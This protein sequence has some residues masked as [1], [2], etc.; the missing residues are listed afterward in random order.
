MLGFFHDSMSSPLLLQEANSPPPTTSLSSA[1]TSARAKADAVV[2]GNV[3]SAPPGRGGAVTGA[4]AAVVVGLV[5]VMLVAVVS[6]Y[7]A[8]KRRNDVN[9]DNAEMKADA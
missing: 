7:I 6:A 3:F 9:K 4:I 8:I 2:G 1:D 5:F